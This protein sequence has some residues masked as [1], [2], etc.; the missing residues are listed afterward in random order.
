[1]RISDNNDFEGISEGKIESFDTS[2]MRASGVEW[3]S[4]NVSSLIKL[5]LKYKYLEKYSNTKYKKY[6]AFS[7]K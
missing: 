3:L 2:V 1:L 7:K 5:G 6:E 4:S